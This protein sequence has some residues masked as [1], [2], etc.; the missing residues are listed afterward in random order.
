[1]TTG[2]D[3]TDSTQ[4]KLPPADMVGMNDQEAKPGTL[5]AT[6]HARLR[7]RHYSPSTERSYLGWVRRYVEFCGRKH[8][9]ELGPKD[10]RRFL[11]SLVSDYD[12]SESTHH[13]ALCAVVFL[14][15]HVLD[16]VVPWLDD[17]ARPRHTTYLPVVLTH[18]EAT[19]LINALEGVPKLMASVLYG[20]GLRV[21][22]C[23]RLRVK[24]L[25][26]SARQIFVRRGKGKKDRL[27]LFPNS[28][29]EPLQQHLMIVKSQH[30][31]DLGSG[32]GYVELPGAL[33][34]KY[35]TAAREWMWQWAFPATRQYRDRET[36][37]LRRHHLHETVLQ[38]AVHSAVRCVGIT[39]PASCHSLRH[40]FATR[41]LE[42]GYDIRTI[43]ELLGHRDVATTMIYTH[44]L[45]RG[46][47]GVR[48]PID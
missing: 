8:P 27:T 23:A 5:L 22:E 9:R 29:R 33:R 37:E 10:F 34:T 28:L 47:F 26:F 15:R 42:A 4:L 6:L 38:R 19:R 48:S 40:S 1:V 25:D 39:K 43:Q 7:E 17:F 18:E 30:D 2:S 45:N 21:L 36:G 35:P 31:M 24:D 44:V 20:S 3:T 13:Q 11:D 41:L 14:Y 32:G 12:V 16:M 46:P